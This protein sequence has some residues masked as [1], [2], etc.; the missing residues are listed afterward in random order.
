M[1]IGKVAWV[2]GAGKGIGEAIALALGKAGI[3]VAVSARTQSDIEKVAASITHL[4]GAA[5][6]VPCD[7]TQP[8]SVADAVSRVR[9]SLGPISIL[10]NNAGAADSHKFIGHDDALW[11]RMIDANLNSV[12]YVTKA[13]APMMAEANWGR[14]INIASIASKVGAKYVAA[15]TASKHGVLGLTRVLA[16]EL[17]S[18]NITV[19]AICPGYVD[20]PMTDKAVANITSR[21]KLSEAEARATLEK[22][23]PQNRL[24]TPEEV[25]HVALML[26]GEDARGITGQAINVDGGAVMF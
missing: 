21:T 8:V 23:S 11:R 18:Y 6:P 25:A 1:S 19:N 24:I 14:I 4:G 22:L 12:Y 2:T 15:Y 13:V 7:V 3:K 10:V 17:V 9:R 16:V 20:T 5:I 26:I